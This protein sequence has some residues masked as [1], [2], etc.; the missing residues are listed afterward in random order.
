MQRRATHL[1]KA[2]K[3]FEILFVFLVS[4]CTPNQ[5]KPRDRASDA[6]R[7]SSQIPEV[8]ASVGNE[9]IT[10]ADIRGR[11][12]R[13]LQRIDTQYQLIRSQVIDAT[14]DSVIRDRTIGAEAHKQGK[15]VDDLVLSEAGRVDPSDAEIQAWYNSN[16]NRTGGRTL[17]SLKPQIA[18]L[19]RQEKLDAAATRLEARLSKE[20]EV[21]VFFEPYRFALDNNGAPV[22]GS[23]RAPIT[24]IEF[25]DFQCPFCQRFSKTLHQIERRYGDTVRIIYRQFPIESIHPFAV[26]A[27]EASLCANE[28]GRFWDL[29]DAMFEDQAHLAVADLKAKASRLGMDRRRFDSC[30]D[31]RRH[32]QQVQKDI[33]EGS[34]LGVSGTP[35]IFLN[36]IELRGGAVPYAVVA[37][38]IDKEL[39]RTKRRP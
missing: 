39:R 5:E 22:K 8:L 11:A 15:S 34:R 28:Q 1:G 23:V 25:S 29:H 32:S 37:A 4:S 13:D 24:L 31:S 9:T 16:G 18:N 26:G 17:E 33:A 3:P 38:A 20:K 30:M 19:L 27:A 6:D 21:A 35:A 10:M 7:S 14:L 2:R 36:G 12:G